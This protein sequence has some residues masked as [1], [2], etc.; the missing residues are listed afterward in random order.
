MKVSKVSLLLIL[1]F[2]ITLVPLVNAQFHAGGQGL[3]YTHSARTLEKGGLNAFF[4]SRFFGKGIE[5]VSGPL[6]IWDVQ[7]SFAL[8]YG[9]SN[10][11]EITFQP[12]I[13]QDD[14]LVNSN[15]PDD[16]FFKLKIGSLGSAASKFKYGALVTTRIPLAERHNV[17]YEPYSAGSFEVGFTG[18]SSYASDVLFPNE[19][20]NAHFNLGFNLHND[21]GSGLNKLLP[22]SLENK[23]TSSSL[24]FAVGVG[25]PYDK[26][27]VSAEVHGSFFVQKPP[28]SAYSRESFV[29]FT[30]GVS[31]QLF[32]WVQLNVAADLLLTSGEDATDYNFVTK[33]F[34]ELPDSYPT[35]RINTGVKFNILSA[36]YNQGSERDI[37]VRKAET[38]RDV[39]EQIVRE[40]RETEKAEKELTRIKEERLK[41]EQELERLRKLLEGDGSKKSDKKKNDS[42]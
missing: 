27:N 4:H 19:S 36:S 9:L 23:G 16:L 31:Y 21:S 3:M 39:F 22:D 37:L 42:N 26:W 1:L 12:I 33:P 18:L 41:A 10:R 34:S 30:P 11:V 20:L 8:T 2:T 28:V 29:Y 35:W 17:L 13:Y 15:I 24:N 14:A 25:Q 40:Q 32:D 6:T 5:Y 38:R 7:G